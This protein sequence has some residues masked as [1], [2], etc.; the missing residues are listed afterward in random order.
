VVEP[1][2]AGGASRGRAPPQVL[3]AATPVRAATRRQRPLQARAPVCARQLGAGRTVI[4]MCRGLPNVPWHRRRGCADHYRG[5]GRSG[6]GGAPCHGAITVWEP[7]NGSSTGGSPGRHRASFSSGSLGWFS[8][9]RRRNPE[10][11]LGGVPTTPNSR[12]DLDQMCGVPRRAHPQAAKRP[13]PKARCGL[14]SG[15]P[16][17][18]SF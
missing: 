18:R 16:G 3:P 2:A 6:T 13:T 10:P 17:E 8:T 14:G 1:G 7:S 11:A 12:R 15:R 4:G 5:Y 9:G